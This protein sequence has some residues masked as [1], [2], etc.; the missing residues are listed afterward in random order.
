MVCIIVIVQLTPFGICS[1][2]MGAIAGSTSNIDLAALFLF[3]FC[4]IG[5]MLCH[6]VRRP[7]ESDKREND[8]GWQAPK[9]A[10]WVTRVLA[11]RQG[12]TLA[13]FCQFFAHVAPVRPR[14]AAAG[15]LQLGER[16]ARARAERP[17]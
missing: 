15:G 2:I 3:M 11:R 4:A 1:L 5:A 6:M 17:D 7:V 9:G 16:A 13:F 14:R 10:P 12:V 8:R